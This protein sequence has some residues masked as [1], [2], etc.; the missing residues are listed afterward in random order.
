[1]V[2]PGEEVTFTCTVIEQ[3]SLTWKNEQY[4]SPRGRV[5]FLHGDQMEVGVPRYRDP[6]QIV[7]TSLDPSNSS[8][9]ANMTSTLTVNTTLTL[10]GTTVECDAV[11][12]SANMTLHI[13]GI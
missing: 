7:L 5:T 12:M 13:A 10:N 2:C 3:P 11:F 6:F 1:M 4:I 9:S 8:Q